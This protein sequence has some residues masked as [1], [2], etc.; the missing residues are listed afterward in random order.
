[1]AMKRS[2]LLAG[3][4]GVTSALV[5][6]ACA[7]GSSSRGGGAVDAAPAAFDTGTGSASARDPAGHERPDPPE[8]GNGGGGGKMGSGEGSCGGC[9]G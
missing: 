6:A 7:H 3:I 5:G 2:V 8:R 4:A 9:K 1:M